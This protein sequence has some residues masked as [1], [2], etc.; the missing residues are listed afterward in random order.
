MSGTNT[1]DRDK[2]YTELVLDDSQEGW[3]KD[4]N[5]LNSIVKDQQEL[6]DM[7][8]GGTALILRDAFGGV[9][10]YDPSNLLDIVDIRTNSD[11]EKSGIYYFNILSATTFRWKYNAGSWSGAVTVVADGETWN[12]NPGSCGFDI[13]FRSVMS[14]S[15]CSVIAS[16]AV[17]GPGGEIY[18]NGVLNTV[19]MQAGHWSVNGRW[20]EIAANSVGA[21]ATG[22]II[23]ASVALS[24]EDRSTDSTLGHYLGDGRY[25]PYSPTA[26]KW[27]L[28]VSK[29][30]EAAL[31]DDSASTRII[32]LAQVKNIAG[33]ISVDGYFS[34]P[35]SLH[36]LA[37]EASEGWIG[38]EP[39]IP[40][41]LTWVSGSHAVSG[42]IRGFPSNAYLL[43]TCSPNADG[44][45]KEYEF[46]FCFDLGS[47]PERENHY[48]KVRHVDGVKPSTV[49]DTL[50]SGQSVS[51]TVRAIGFD[52]KASPWAIAA[53]ATTGGTCGVTSSPTYT[54]EKATD[55]FFI[56]DLS[57]ADTPAELG[58]FVVRVKEGATPGVND[59][60]FNQYIYNEGL[61]GQLID[62]YIPWDGTNPYV[63]V[64]PFDKEGVLK[65]ST[66]GASID[67]TACLVSGA[68]VGPNATASNRVDGFVDVSVTGVVAEMTTLRV[69]ARDGG[70]PTLS[71]DEFVME[72]PNKGGTTWSGVIPLPEGD[73]WRIA[74]VG[75]D[76]FGVE[77]TEYTAASTLD[78]SPYVQGYLKVGKT[79]CHYTTI[80]SAINRVHTL[81][82]TQ[83]EIKIY[84]GTYVEDL[85]FPSGFFCNLVL[86][87]ELG[88]F[89]EGDIEF[90]GVG[91]DSS[92]GSWLDGYNA[93]ETA[94]DKWPF[95]VYDVTFIGHG[96]RAS[97]SII[98]SASIW[99]LFFERCHFLPDGT[100]TDELL[101]LKQDGDIHSTRLV[102]YFK[103]CR[104]DNPNACTRLI[105]FD[106]DTATH[107][108]HDFWFEDC[109][110]AGECSDSLIRKYGSTPN[111]YD[112]VHTY[113]NCKMQN[114]DSSG[115]VTSMNGNLVLHNNLF[116]TDS[117]NLFNIGVIQQLGCTIAGVAT[118]SNVTHS[119]PFLRVDN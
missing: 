53:T 70:D 82:L 103:H 105:Y 33:V 101:H 92:V 28:T 34:A 24:T 8:G 21:L 2:N 32:P 63:T 118:D 73:D 4:F 3:A 29:S 116:H 79:G 56:R 109:V 7:L 50:Q 47:S 19:S 86:R 35:L 87:G 100:G 15:S 54:L 27:T 14:S 78:V 68:V 45:T 88:V 102:T 23:Y 31:P 11:F 99:G 44:K 38:G 36:S 111:P 114:V 91:G 98:P 66:V 72:V 85:T 42:A 59:I 115:F 49:L 94:E 37:R 71:D 90:G 58:G 95:R 61:L 46:K 39:S 40:T 16:K 10:T 108:G 55:G 41:G 81:G 119:F 113:S 96:T 110:L 84:P 64:E 18:Y 13:V 9:Y 83:A 89:I 67:L 104:F 43:A 1:Y 75:T 5:H 117:G 62:L 52:G 25:H 107:A 93:Y 26:T 51:V 80:Q 74:V 97:Q 65:G 12:K 6:L 20:I 17:R 106:R 48:I 30:A 112:Y 69:Y 57:D 22:D 76:R 60:Y 77:H